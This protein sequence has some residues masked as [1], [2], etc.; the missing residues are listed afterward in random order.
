MFDALGALGIA[1]NI[2]QLVDFTGDLLL[3]AK[4][5]HG[6]IEGALVENLELEAVAV[7]VEKLSRDIETALFIRKKK[8]DSR[9]RAREEDLRSKI[10]QEKNNSTDMVDPEKKEPNSE[11]DQEEL[12]ESELRSL[13]QTSVNEAQELLGALRQ[14]KV[15]K[16]SRSR[17]WASFRAALKSVWKEDKIDAL[18][19]RLST[20]REF[21]TS[22]ILM[23]I[24]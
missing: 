11:V 6:S 19:L 4:H 17:K 3:K 9:K 12:N 16:D 23:A 2:I 1:A 14:L 22:R 13:C 21:I 18:A 24:R 5:I 10:I 15:S 7:H 20:T 8:D